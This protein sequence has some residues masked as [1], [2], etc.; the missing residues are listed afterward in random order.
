[1]RE[2][3]LTM[4]DCNCGERAERKTRAPRT[5]ARGLPAPDTGHLSAGVRAAGTLEGRALGL[6]ADGGTPGA[7]SRGEAGSRARAAV[8][9]PG[10]RATRAPHE[11]KKT[12]NA[13][14]RV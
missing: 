7:E 6:G 14:E 5:A 12:I 2:K 8:R 4:C 11:C 10:R 13:K 1:M 9:V 3:C